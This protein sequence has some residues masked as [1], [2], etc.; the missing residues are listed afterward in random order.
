MEPPLTVWRAERQKA[1]L[2]NLGGKVADLREVMN[3][4]LYVNR[5]GTPWRYPPH[6]FPPHTTVF[7]H[8]SAW[9][10]DGYSCSWSPRPGSST[11]PR[12]WR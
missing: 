8:F 10:A 6:D 1:S 12:E 11:T 2:I 7:S 3:A 5:T 9:T 4:I